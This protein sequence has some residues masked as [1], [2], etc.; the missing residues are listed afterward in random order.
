MIANNLT[1]PITNFAAYLSERKEQIEEFLKESLALKPVASRLWEA[2]RYSSLNGGKRLR[3][4]LCL[5]ACEAINPSVYQKALPVAAA[6]ECVH[7]MSLIHDDLPCMDN[8]NLRRGK[9]TCHIAYDEATALLAGDALLVEGL[10]LCLKAELEPQQTLAIAQELTQAI[11]AHGMTGGQMID[12]EKTNSNE[13][14]LAELEQMHKLKTGALLRASVVCGG[15]AGG[16]SQKQLS[17]FSN[18]AQKIGL[19]FQIIDDVLDTESDAATLGKTAG[20]D[21]VQNK[22]TY[23]KLIGLA[24][25]KERAEILVYEAKSCLAEA[26]I[27]FDPLSKIANYVIERKN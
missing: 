25:S 10:S 19:A 8:D 9:P 21:L 17:A 16:A 2:M 14:T 12:L 22:T 7:A 26:Q 27:N 23:P 13:T 3:G 1:E 20:K 11:G 15:I 5:A 24:Q 6:L 4:I 18:Y